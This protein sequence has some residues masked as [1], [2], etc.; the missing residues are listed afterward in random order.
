MFGERVIASRILF[1]DQ[2]H[3]SVENFSSGPGIGAG[4]RT[5]RVALSCVFRAHD[6][7]R[8]TCADTGEDEGIIFEYRLLLTLLHGYI[9]TIHLGITY[10]HDKGTPPEGGRRSAIVMQSTTIVSRGVKKEMS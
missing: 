4:L 5:L 10:G 7:L 6:L 1:D 9:Y 8:G 2:D 3:I